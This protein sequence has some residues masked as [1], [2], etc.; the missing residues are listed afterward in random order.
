VRR[1]GQN[2]PDWVAE[3]YD[4]QHNVDQMVAVYEAVLKRGDRV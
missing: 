2:G 3:R 1:L 4:F